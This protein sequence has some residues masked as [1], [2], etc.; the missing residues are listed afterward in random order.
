[1]PKLQDAAGKAIRHHEPVD[2]AAVSGV[3]T[4]AFIYYWYT[5]LKKYPDGIHCYLGSIQILIEVLFWK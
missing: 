2:S 5:L 4:R 1:P 3:N